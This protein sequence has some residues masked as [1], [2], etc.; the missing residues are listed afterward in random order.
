VVNPRREFFFA[1]P[2]EIRELLAAKVGSL[3][4]FTDQPEAI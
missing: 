1:S 4:E 3:L 2:A